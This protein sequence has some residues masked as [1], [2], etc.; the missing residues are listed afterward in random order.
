VAYKRAPLVFSD[1]ARIAQHLESGRL[2]LAFAGKA[3]PQDEE[4]Q[5]LVGTLVAM[6]RK[7]PRGV[8]FLEDYGMAIGR[9][10]TRGC[11][12]WLNNPRRP[13]EASG[14]SGMKAAMNGVLNASV[15]DGWWPEACEDGV[16]GWAIGAGFESGDD[17]AQDAHDA[18]DLYRVLLE[19]IIPTY[20][21][22]R[23]RWLEMMRA[24]IRSTVSRFGTERMLRDYAV[25]MYAV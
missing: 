16:N 8:V 2:Q 23:A 17:A 4:G 22:D 5:E 11:D 1:E 6:A 19:E 14:T 3:H 20:Y 25:L 15:L 10:M 7:Y 24:S 13:K 12:V 18:A 21:D 9:A